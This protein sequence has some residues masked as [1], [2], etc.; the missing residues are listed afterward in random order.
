MHIAEA[1]AKIEKIAIG[2]ERRVRL[3]AGRGTEE[4]TGVIG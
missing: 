1:V 3:L 4:V 2:N